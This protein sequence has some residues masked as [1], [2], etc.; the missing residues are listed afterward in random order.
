MSGNNFKIDMP[1]IGEKLKPKII[2]AQDK[3]SDN[4]RVVCVRCTEN[5][6]RI[7]FKE[8]A[9]DNDEVTKDIMNQKQY[10]FWNESQKVWECPNCHDREMPDDTHIAQPQKKLKIVGVPLSNNGTPQDFTKAV[11][12]KRMQDV[13]FTPKEI[14]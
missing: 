9:P 14:F 8:Q 2:I 1:E 4:N 10:M 7:F 3:Q 11:H 12:K 6:F 5:F 13:D